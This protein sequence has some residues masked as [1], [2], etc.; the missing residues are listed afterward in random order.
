MACLG[1]VLSHPG[2]D[3]QW[4]PQTRRSAQ[5]PGNRRSCQCRARMGALCGSVT[6][7][8]RV[9]VTAPAYE[10]TY[11]LVDGFPPRDE[12]PALCTNHSRMPGSKAAERASITCMRSLLWRMETPRWRHERYPRPV[13]GFRLHAGYAAADRHR[14]VASAPAARRGPSF[15]IQDSADSAIANPLRRRSI[16]R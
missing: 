15:R 2:D 11:A 3:G 14:T 9:S 7:R 4:R 10:L 6:I 16:T 13:G 8:H 12:Q 1:A 5:C